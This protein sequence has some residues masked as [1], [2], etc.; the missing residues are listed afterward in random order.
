MADL[1]ME[2]STGLNVL[3]PVTLRHFLVKMKHLLPEAMPIPKRTLNM[4]ILMM[5][6][7]IL[8]VET[9]VISKKSVMSVEWLFMCLL[10]SI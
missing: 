3:F 2:A 4:T 1:R 10:L 5:E 6:T 7:T 9:K 8:M